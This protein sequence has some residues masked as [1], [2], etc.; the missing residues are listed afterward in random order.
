MQK[1]NTRINYHHSN[2]FNK[3]PIYLYVHFNFPDHRIQDL[4]VQPIDTVTDKVQPL[5]EFRK[6]ERYWIRTLKTLDS[7]SAL[8]SQLHLPKLQIMHM[9]QLYIMSCNTMLAS[10]FDHLHEKKRGRAPTP[11]GF[12]DYT[13]T[14]TSMCIHTCTQL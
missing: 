13:H 6:L 5:E 14:Y 7:I 3:K 10:L 11:C 2:I 8:V 1:L 12:F 4:S 9:N